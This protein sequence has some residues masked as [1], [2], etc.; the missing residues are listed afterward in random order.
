MKKISLLFILFA[1]AC[2]TSQNHEQLP[3]KV[4]VN[5]IG[6]YPG[7]VK[8]AVI[9]TDSVTTFKV[10]NVANGKTVY[11]SDLSSPIYQE[12][13]NQTVRIADF[14]K[15]T[16]QGEYYV[17]VPGYGIST[18]FPIKER[19]YDDAFITSMRAFY[20]WRCGMEV[21]AEY[22]GDHFHNDACHLE[23]GKTDYIGIQGGTK[24]GTGGWHDAGDFGKYTVNAGATVGVLFYAWDHFRNMIEKCDLDLPVTAPNYP[25][26]LEEIKWETDFILKMQYPD[27]SGRVSH[28]LTR[29]N[30]ADFI[31][32]QD[33]DGE[34]F[35]TEWSSA[36]TADFIAM[37]AKASVVFAPYDKEYAQKCLDAAL[38]SWEFLKNSPEKPF[39]QGDFSTGGYQTG[40][41][42]D[43]LWASAELWA[44]T[45]REDCL[46]EAEK[47]ISEQEVM[48]DS[49]WDW[50]DLSNLG[51]YAYVLCD[52]TG[53]DEN[54]VKKAKEAII[55]NADDLAETAEK[56]VYGRALGG[57]YYWGCNG[58]VGRQALNLHMA[59][60]ISPNDKYDKAIASIVGHLFGN[61]YY[62]RSY[63]TGVGF[64]PPMHP[65]DRRSGA[66]DIDN[67]WPGY[68]VGGGHS[69]IDWV[70]LQDDYS[71]NEIAINWQA[72][73]VY[74]LAAALQ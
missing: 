55:A 20:L 74:A 32:P 15:V 27:G 42:D 72:G 8:T 64:N 16:Q 59:D 45:G 71:R 54:L 29:R 3:I 5:S 33:D 2:C 30:F 48:V 39:I 69:A 38:I 52:R 50:G 18:I 43:R 10:I 51:V 7:S 13:V 57:T 67:P 28:K 12:D 41:K 14:T 4:V 24:D 37:L 31:M 17:E 6:F 19:S 66:D 73:L 56:D 11:K 23:D 46:K 58:T 65:H 53:R 62:N 9:P 35:F 26:F 44:A 36:A 70:D 25:E 40:D 1:M 61:N 34:R 22:H 68:L 63:V 49:S 21:D 47:L 60:I